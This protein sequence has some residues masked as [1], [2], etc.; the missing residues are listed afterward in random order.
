MKFRIPNSELTVTY[1]FYELQRRFEVSQSVYDAVPVV[2]VAFDV[3]APHEINEAFL[4]ENDWIIREAVLDPALVPVLDMLTEDMAG[5][6][7]ATEIFEAQWKVQMAV[8]DRLKSQMSA[9]VAFREQARMDIA[10]AAR[11]GA[12]AAQRQADEV[13]NDAMHLLGLPSW[14][15]LTS[16]D[17]LLNGEP[18]QFLGDGLLGAASG[19]IAGKKPTDEMAQQILEWKEADLA[20]VERQLQEASNA[21]GISTEK[22]IAA[23]RRRLNRRIQIDQLI[24]HVRANIIHYMQSIWTKEHSDQRYLRLYDLDIEWPEPSGD[25]IYV[26]AEDISLSVPGPPPPSV[27][28]APSISGRIEM[29][30][31]KLGE[32]RKLHQVADLDQILGFRGNYVVFRLKESNALTDFML[33]DYMDTGFG[34]GDPDLSVLVPTSEEALAL[35]TCLLERDDLTKEEQQE[36]CDWAEQV[37]QLG[38][39]RETEVIVPTGQLFIEAL[40][41]THPLLEDFKL[42][43]R[44]YDMQK[45]RADARMA[46]LEAD[47]RARLLDIDDLDDPDVDKTIE[48]T[49]LGDGS[50]DV[51]V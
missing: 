36:I 8:V 22:Y 25:P 27:L 31:A 40:P 42:R 2:M 47:R 17:G 20:R 32:K 49:G 39:E 37:I 9:H 43:H 1:L 38:I 24:L 12:E 28:N 48:I 41:G 50:V 21:L 5:F 18:F 11:K 30:A 16:L 7:F 34:I 4:I 44:G 29:P 19:A 33:Q 10:V 6:E 14:N 23:V 45:A 3:P 26:P 46:E 15:D 13:Q 35:A 51:D